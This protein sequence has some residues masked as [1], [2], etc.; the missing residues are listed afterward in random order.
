MQILDTH[1]PITAIV[2]ASGVEFDIFL[3]DQT[4]A[5]TRHGLRLAGLIQHRR[6][7]PG[8]R[9]CDIELEDLATGLRHGISED[10]GAGAQGCTL[11]ADGLLRACDAAGGGLDGGTDLLVL[12][13]FGKAEIEGGGC[14]GL[15]ARALDLGVPVLIGVPEN[16]LA[17]FREFTGGLAHE[18]A[19]RVC[20]GA[21]AAEG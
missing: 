21:Q 20:A 16:H 1:G 7:V 14:R 6:A 8:R 9:K 15:I 2:Y 12:S 11:D 17:A 4:A 13:R 5:M 10:R 19:L 3:R 18:I